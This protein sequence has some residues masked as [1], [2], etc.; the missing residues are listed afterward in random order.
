MTRAKRSSPESGVYNPRR[1]VKTL[2]YRRYQNQLKLCTFFSCLPRLPRYLYHIVYCY[3][4][5]LLFPDQPYLMSTCEQIY[6]L[7]AQFID[8]LGGKSHPW[9]VSETFWSLTKARIYTRLEGGKGKRRRPRIQG[10]FRCVTFSFTHIYWPLS[11]AVA[12]SVA[13]VTG[14]RSLE[15]SQTHPA[16]LGLYKAQTSWGKREREGARN[17]I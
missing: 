6:T 9:S 2:S 8:Q 13:V 15:A 10:I 7:R 16:H 3:F 11:E 5:S 14:W 12:V 4:F 17:W 1:N